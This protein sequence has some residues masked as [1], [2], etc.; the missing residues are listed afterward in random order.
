MTTIHV[1]LIAE[2]AVI[3]LTSVPK[4]SANPAHAPLCGSITAVIP[5]RRS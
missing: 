1:N 2:E 5:E 3:K 4:I